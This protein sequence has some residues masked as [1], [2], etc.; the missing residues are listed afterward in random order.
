MID[1]VLRSFK[2]ALAIKGIRRALWL[3][4]AIATFLVCFETQTNYFEINAIS[5]R[6]EILQKAGQQPLAAEQNARI[7]KLKNGVLEEL[8]GVQTKRA[9]RISEF[10][11]L[12]VRF[13]KGAWITLPLFWLVIKLVLLIFKHSKTDDLRV[14][15]MMFYFGWLGL[16]AVAWFTTMLGIISVVWNTSGNI[17]I[18]WFLF[19]I[20]A[21]LI[22]IVFIFWMFLLRSLLP[23]NAKEHPPLAARSQEQAAVE[24]TE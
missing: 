11:G 1:Q 16:S 18:S 19:P 15:G 10:G 3:F 12:L 17:L 13:V 4:L 22:L 6:L 21:A 24:S 5:K 2:D 14:K 7:E 23:K 9:N 8:E 20:C